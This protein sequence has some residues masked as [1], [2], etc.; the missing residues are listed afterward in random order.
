MIGTKNSL[1]T[2][3]WPIKVTSKDTIRTLSTLD[4]AAF[5]KFLKSL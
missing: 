4:R 5:I 2:D 3:G 1:G